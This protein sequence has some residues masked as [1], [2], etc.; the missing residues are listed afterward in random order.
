[1]KGSVGDEIVVDHPACGGDVFKSV[2]IGS[3]VK[4]GAN[5][6]FASFV[7]IHD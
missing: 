7:A 5:C 3:R 1:M 6:W 2:S 4:I